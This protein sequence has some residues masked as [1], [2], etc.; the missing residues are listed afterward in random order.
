MPSRNTSANAVMILGRR[1]ELLAQVTL[2]SYIPPGIR[3]AI[4]LN[5]DGVGRD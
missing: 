3:V 1:G 2:G 5:D 4:R